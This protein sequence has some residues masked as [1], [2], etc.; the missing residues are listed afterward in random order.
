M[1]QGRAVCLESGSDLSFPT[2]TV[3]LATKYRLILFK[4]SFDT[5]NTEPATEEEEKNI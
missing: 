2:M 3:R 4:K 5:Q 1:D